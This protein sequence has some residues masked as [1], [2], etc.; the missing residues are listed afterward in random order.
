MP[1]TKTTPA[2]I[3]KTPGVCGGD[4]CIRNTRIAVWMMVELKKQNA[5][6]QR[7]LNAFPDLTREDLE[8]AWNYYRNHSAE[9]ESALH[10]Q[11]SE[12]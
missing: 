8:A 3:Q 11:D 6:E 9:I 12:N 2:L 7:I 1:I 4:A 10:E 5:S